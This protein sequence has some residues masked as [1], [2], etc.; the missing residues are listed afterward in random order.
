MPEYEEVEQNT[1]PE[2]EAESEETAEQPVPP[3]P[4]SHPQSVDYGRFQEVNE[5][6]RFAEQRAHEL[7]MALLNFQTAQQQQQK[8]SEPDVDPEVEQLVAPILKKQLASYENRL[9]AIQQREAAMY[10]NQEAQAAWDYVRSSVPDL[11]ELA[12]DI[13]T[14]LQSIPAKRAGL[15]TS[16][17]DLVIQTAE[18]VRAKK[19]AGQAIGSQAAKQDLK[20]RGKGDSGTSTTSVSGTKTYNWATMS[21]K[22]IAEAERKLGIRS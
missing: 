22:E 7:Q 15:I 3:Q 11:D 10:A 4:Q 5:R 12:N 16:D 2:V 13:Q 20:A 19:A 17:P 21:D 9:Q 18:L 8:A 1:N 6:M 14:Y